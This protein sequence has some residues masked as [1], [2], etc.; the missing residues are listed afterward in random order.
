M[1]KWIEFNTSGLLMIDV[2]NFS[3]LQ[4]EVFGHARPRL[5]RVHVRDFLKGNR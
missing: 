2:M 5:K 1:V 3:M 4:A